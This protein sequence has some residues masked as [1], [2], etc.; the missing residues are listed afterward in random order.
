MSR[1]VAGVVIIQDGQVLLG[2][3]E[4]YGTWGLPGG[5]VEN[6]ESVAQAALREIRE[7]L[8]IDVQLTRLIGVYSRPHWRNG[9]YHVVVFAARP[10]GGTL[11]P[12]PGEVVD[13]RYFDPAA[14]P[15]LLP[16][17]MRLQIAAALADIGGGIA[18]LDDTA[19]PLAPDMTQD[20]L[21][22]L[23]RNSGLSGADFVRGFLPQAGTITVEVGR[24]HSKD[25]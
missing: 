23:Y 20:E 6:G 4:R 10:V 16:A 9:G 12:D 21:D 5:L 18:W 1:V 22:D 24:Q 2:K 13:A 25:E 8:G 3:N 11:Q 7:E 15:D 19:W 14:L 17:G